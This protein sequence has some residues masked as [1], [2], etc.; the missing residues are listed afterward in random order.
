MG[1]ILIFNDHVTRMI[2]ICNT[3][4]DLC[5]LVFVPLG[6]NLPNEK[7]SISLYGIRAFI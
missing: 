5:I 6:P 2:A 1:C 7:D 3:D 4:F